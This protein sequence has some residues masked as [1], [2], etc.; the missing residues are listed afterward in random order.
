MSQWMIDHIYEVIVK[1]SHPMVDILKHENVG[2][3]DAILSQAQS[4]KY[5]LDLLHQYSSPPSPRMEAPNVP[6]QSD[7]IV[8]INNWIISENERKDGNQGTALAGSKG[9]DQ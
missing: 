3:K 2:L 8:A 6:S 4:A 1:M 5:L 9:G 7:S